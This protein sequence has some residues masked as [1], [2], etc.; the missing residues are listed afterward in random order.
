MRFGTLCALLLR[1]SPGVTRTLIQVCVDRV[2]AR[3]ERASPQDP[4][5]DSPLRILDER[6][7]LFLVLD[8]VDE[9]DALVAALVCTIFRDELFKQPRHAVRPADK[10]YAGKRLVTSVAGVASSARRLVWARTLGL[11][12]PAWVRSWSQ[13]TCRNLACVGALDALQWAR[14]NGC[15]WDARVCAGAAWKGHLPVLQW[16]RANGCRWTPETCTGAAWKGHLEILKWA[17]ANGCPWNA[18]A[19]TVA[20][21]EG[22]LEVLQWAR[23]NGCEWDEK[24]CAHAAEEGHLEVLQWARANGCVWDAT[25]CLRAAMGGHLKVLQWARAQGCPWTAETCSHAAW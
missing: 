3:P 7:A 15:A 16:A 14:A 12:A 1:T 5:R 22:H 25:T 23:A 6:S 8:Q 4:L 24:T 17:R 9:D 10:P 11:Q 2:A 20:A 18:N 13:V 21:E 19:C